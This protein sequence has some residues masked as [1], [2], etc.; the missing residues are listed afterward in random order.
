VSEPDIPPV[1]SVSPAP[2]LWEAMLVILLYFALQ[3]VL[4]FVVGRALTGLNALLTD[5]GGAPIPARMML[6]LIVIATLLLASVA[7][8][9]TVHWRWRGWLA[10]KALP[11]LGFVQASGNMLGLAILTGLLT[12]VI[13]GLLTQWLAGGHEVSQAISTIGVGTPLG[14]RIVLVAVVISAG[15]LVEEALFRGVLLAGLVRYMSP[16][17]AIL[18]SATLFA[19]V[20]LPD[21]HGAAYALPNL[22]L[23]AWFCGWLRVR[24]GSIWPAVLAHGLNNLLATTA[25]FMASS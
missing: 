7:T 12:P 9:A 1:A 4:G 11:G 5:G 19:L 24:S 16:G 3:L 20:H 15:P 25:W 18:A 23:L 22:A 17:I 10:V 6:P 8:L 14:L 21:L 2:K 13:G